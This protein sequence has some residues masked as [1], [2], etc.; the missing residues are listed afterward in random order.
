MPK[1]F[2][3]QPSDHEDTTLRVENIKDNFIGIYIR[4]SYRGYTRKT[5]PIM[6]LSDMS[7]SR[8]VFPING[9][10]PSTGNCPI[11]IS[12]CEDVPFPFLSTFFCSMDVR[13]LF[14]VIPRQHSQTAGIYLKDFIQAV[15]HAEISY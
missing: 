10:P 11:S 6:M 9:E 13:R 5:I 12:S 8:I 1:V 7:A 2:E 3:V 4:E 15:F 14:Q